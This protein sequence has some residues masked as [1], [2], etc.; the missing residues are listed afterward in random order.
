MLLPLLRCQELPV[1]DVQ[2]LARHTGEDCHE[3]PYSLND[4]ATCDLIF[5]SPYVAALKTFSF[6]VAQLCH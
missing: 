2:S 4:I 3:V 1:T 5:T 6:H